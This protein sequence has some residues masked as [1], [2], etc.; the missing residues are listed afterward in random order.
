MKS[1]KLVDVYLFV[2][3]SSKRFRGY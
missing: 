3:W 1:V 2:I